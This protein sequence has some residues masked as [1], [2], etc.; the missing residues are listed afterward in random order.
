MAMRM[1]RLTGWRS[2]EERGAEA[3]ERDR[4]TRV[5]RPRHTV[6]ATGERNALVEDD[7]GR[8]NDITIFTRDRPTGSAPP[9]SEEHKPMSESAARLT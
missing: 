2:S 1:R 5:R 6:H 8:F 4:R 9:A 7:A 3:D